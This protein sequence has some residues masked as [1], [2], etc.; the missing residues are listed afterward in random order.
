M[1]LIPEAR[2]WQC[3]GISRKQYTGLKPWKKAGLKRRLFEDIV[4]A[5]PD[6]LIQEIKRHGEA[7]HLIN[8]IFGASNK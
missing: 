4:L 2:P 7:E 8:L 3:L 6:H 5:L 1:P